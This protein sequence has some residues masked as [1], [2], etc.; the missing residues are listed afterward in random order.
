MIKVNIISDVVRASDV[1][2]DMRK[3]A[4]HLWNSFPTTQ[5]LKVTIRRHQTQFEGHP[6]ESLT[7]GLF[8]CVTVMKDKE[9]QKHHP[10]WRSQQRYDD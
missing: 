9:R 10:G 5:N 8:R 4:P 6:T 3:R 1:L 7:L 2:Y